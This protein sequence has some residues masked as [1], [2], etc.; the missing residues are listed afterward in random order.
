MPPKLIPLRST[1]LAVTA[2]AVL[3]A[4]G[5]AASADVL[6]SSFE[7]SMDSS[8][9]GSWAVVDSIGGTP[10]DQLWTPQFVG[11]GATDGS[12]ALRV[13]HGQNSW[14]HGLRLDSTAIIP[15][16]ANSDTF[17]FDVTAP[18]GISWRAI[19]VIMQGDGMSWTQSEQV[20]LISGQTVHAVIDLTDVTP[21]NATDTANWKAGAQASGGQWWQIWFAIMGQDNPPGADIDFDG[22]VDG[23][24]FLTI[25]RNLGNTSAGQEQ[26]DVN[27]DG[28]VDDTD[29]GIWGVDFGRSATSAYTIIDNIKF[30]G[31]ATGV[32]SAVPEPSTLVG[33]AIGVAVM[34]MARRRR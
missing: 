15:I 22:D 3:L 20:N 30:V 28:I 16:V 27:F 31:A 5:S 11:V 8:A 7:G 26:G 2:F 17:E 33:G 9:G 18:E 21:S 29:V 19:W 4:F 25:Q 34:A 1:K 10:G 24:D 13:D 32:V 12:Q 14:E 6:L 23:A